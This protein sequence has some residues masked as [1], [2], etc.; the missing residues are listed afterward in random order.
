MLSKHGV[1]DKVAKKS[2]SL[3][4]P[5][6]GTTYAYHIYARE[7]SRPYATRTLFLRTAFGRWPG[8][9]LPVDSE[10]SVCSLACG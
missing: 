7:G 3:D 4:H 9:P 10:E 5:V 8:V 2:L 1:S 6:I